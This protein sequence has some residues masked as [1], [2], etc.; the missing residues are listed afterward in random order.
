MR[1][2][3][4][5]KQG[6][7]RISEVAKATGV[8]LPT[9]HYY[10]REGLLFPSLKTAHNMAYYSPDCV[11]DILLIKELQ[12]NKFLPLS[13]I[14]IIL[15]ARRDGQ[16]IEH[17]AEMESVL[18]DIFQPTLDETKSGSIS[19][20]ELVSVSGLTETDIKELVAKGVIFAS[21]T[22][23]GP[24]FEGIDMRIAQIAKRLFTFGLKPADFE[25]Y[26]QYMEIIRSEF[27]TMHE[28][29]HHLPNHEVISLKE[30]FK[31]AS[32]FKGCLAIKIYR[33]EARHLQE[34]S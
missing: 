18:G 11:K 4:I 13:V 7:L 31:L 5:N 12:S 15:Q 27:K 22:E 9:I 1:K 32:D 21:E 26:R 25:I 17:V 24:V 16:D 6:L 19:L 29:I 3:D 8:S 33:Q 28:I 2:S 30:L 20:A 14:K 34:H 23:K 10:T